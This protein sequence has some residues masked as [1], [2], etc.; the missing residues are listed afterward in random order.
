MKKKLFLMLITM[1]AVGYVNISQA[2][3]EEDWESASF[4]PK[5]K[6]EL[7]KAAELKKGNMPE[8]GAGAVKTL[9]NSS[10]KPIYIGFYISNQ[11][12]Y[13]WL[14]DGKT[15]ANDPTLVV[16]PGQTV[17]FVPPIHKG[18]MGTYYATV[19]ISTSNQDLQS[20]LQQ[21]QLGLV[22]K[23]SDFEI[24]IVGPVSHLI[25]VGYDESKLKNQ[26]FFYTKALLK[27]HEPL[28]Y[29]QV[30]AQLPEALEQQDRGRGDAEEKEEEEGGGEMAPP[31]YP[32]RPP[33]YSA[34]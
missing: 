5:D 13:P 10:T 3:A 19:V 34:E 11:R 32:D 8:S 17:R 22:G 27:S 28:S 1:W 25:T 9:H 6:K 24:V 30:Q 15:M 7:E 29:E 4:S 14:E 16:S 18:W 2:A 23:S 31:C 21:R 33:S 20:K 12:L 26:K